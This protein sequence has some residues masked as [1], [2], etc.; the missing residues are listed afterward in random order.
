MFD[1]YYYTSVI[2]DMVSKLI[3]K[4]KMNARMKQAYQGGYIEK[5]QEYL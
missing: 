2:N 3:G 5:L 1:I 4:E